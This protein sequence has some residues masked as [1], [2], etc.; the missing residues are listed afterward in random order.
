MKKENVHFDSSFVVVHV[1]IFPLSFLPFELERKWWKFIH[2]YVLFVRPTNECCVSSQYGIGLQ[3][4][5]CHRVSVVVAG[6]L[7]CGVVSIF[8]FY[9]VLLP[10]CIF[11]F[12]NRNY[13]SFLNG[14]HKRNIRIKEISLSIAL[15][16]SFIRSVL[17]IYYILIDATTLVFKRKMSERLAENKTICLK[18]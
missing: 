8:S 13:E 10:T 12:E 18:A 14:Q 11:L 17:W 5:L 4:I 16:L 6:V 1:R 3:C 7:E 9:N 2:S 15:S